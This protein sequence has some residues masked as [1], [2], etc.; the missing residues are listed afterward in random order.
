MHRLLTTLTFLLIALAATGCIIE[1]APSVFTVVNN[2]AAQI[3]LR[4]TGFEHP[5]VIKVDAH[6][7]AKFRGRTAHGGCLTG[8]EVIDRAGRTLRSIDKI[9]D[10]DTIVYP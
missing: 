1:S 10:G 7:E 6:Q 2:S 5:E 3:A 8:W 9:C 4:Q